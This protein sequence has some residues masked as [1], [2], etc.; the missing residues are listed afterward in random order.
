MQRHAHRLV[1]KLFAPFTRTASWIIFAL[2][3]LM[4]PACS[5]MPSGRLTPALQANL[6]QSCP[7][8]PT[9]PAPLLDPDRS[10]WELAMIALYGDCAGR[11]RATVQAWPKAR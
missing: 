6:A 3:L 1:S 2:F 5:T 8:L 9:P 10:V 4:L 7:S 11:H